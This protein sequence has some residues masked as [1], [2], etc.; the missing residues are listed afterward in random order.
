MLT[1]R[2]PALRTP[3][4][5]EKLL[6]STAQTTGF[7]CALALLQCLFYSAARTGIGAASSPSVRGVERATHARAVLTAAAALT[8]LVLPAQCLAGYLVSLRVV[9]RDQYGCAD[10][11]ADSAARV[12]ALPAALRT[13]LTLHVLLALAGFY[14]GAGAALF[15][16]VLAV[17]ALVVAGVLA[18]VAHATE[19]RLPPEYLQRVGSLMVCRNT[20][21]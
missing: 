19:R 15:W 4:G 2:S 10:W 6:L 16:V 14:D 20:A 12:V 18:A 1:E 9:L 21:R 3:P 5:K 11:G 17:P 7:A 8:A 13:A